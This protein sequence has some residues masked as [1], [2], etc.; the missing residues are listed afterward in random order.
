MGRGPP[1]FRG[2]VEGTYAREAPRGRDFRARETNSGERGRPVSGRMRAFPTP[3]GSSGGSITVVPVFRE[4]RY[5]V[6]LGKSV[7]DLRPGDVTTVGTVQA[8]GTAFRILGE[9]RDLLVTAGHVVRGPGRLQEIE[10]DGKPYVA[11]GDGDSI[12]RIGKRIRI[13]SLSLTPARILWDERYDV[14]LLEVDPKSLDRLGLRRFDLGDD[15]A[16]DVLEEVGVFGFP[17]AATTASPD[18]TAAVLIEVSESRLTLNESISP[19]YSGGPLVIGDGSV[20]GV[21]YRSTEERGLARP[22]SVIEKL[23]ASFDDEARVYSDF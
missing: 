13:G 21:I 19:G 6:R 22:V 17:G 20:V 15:A 3:A 4:T 11:D 18:M 14:A 10:I 5:R 12:H 7:R 23:I 8:R 2:P 16:L 1:A 9:G